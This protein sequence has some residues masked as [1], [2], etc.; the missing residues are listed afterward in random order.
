MKNALRIIGITVIALLAG[1]ALASCDNGVGGRISIP[2]LDTVNI[3][4]SGKDPGAAV[5]APESAD[6]TSN[7]VTVSAVEAPG[8]GQTVEY[9]ISTSN[10]ASTVASWQEEL[11]F[12]NLDPETD[13]YIFAR[14]KEDDTHNAGTPSEGYQV[15]T[16]PSG[17]LAGA[18]VG[19]PVLNVKSTNSITVN[20]VAAP[21]NGQTVEYGINTSNT[22][23]IAW[24]DSTTFSG[25]APVAAYY[26]FARS[27]ENDTY[28]AGIPSAGLEVNKLAGAAVNKPVLE[29]VTSNSITVDAVEA[30]GNGQTVEYAISSAPSVWQNSTTFTELTLGTTYYIFARSK[31]NSTHNAGTPSAGLEVTPLVPS[32]LIILGVP[33][34]L[35][36]D[37]DGLTI[38]S[39]ILNDDFH[40]DIRSMYDLGFFLG[41]PGG[42][43]GGGEI[44]DDGSETVAIYFTIW[45]A[46]NNTKQPYDE[47]FTLVN[48]VLTI[49]NYNVLPDEY[50]VY[51]DITFTNGGA[52]ILWSDFVVY[53]E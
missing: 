34:G 42:T 43:E 28:N 45:L 47:D 33:A 4:S 46:E 52:V 13:Y 8:N 19:T 25:L 51:K 7:S 39:A 3:V 2:E 15:T 29:E 18:V 5:G 23:P 14:S 40:N 49:K 17:K 41:N 30:P 50:V 32:T 26:I 36:D 11:T 35:F 1:F 31:E 10:D 16:N 24:Q 12:S 37:G 27:K 38:E 48:A 20:A 22:P 44:V 53:S 21:G 9:G 6:V